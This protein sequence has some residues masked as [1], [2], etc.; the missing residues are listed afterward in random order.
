MNSALMKE[1]KYKESF[2]AHSN[3]F[4]KIE[5]VDTSK[6]LKSGK[7]LTSQREGRPRG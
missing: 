5:H 2:M 3:N 7:K 6:S 1:T 4:T